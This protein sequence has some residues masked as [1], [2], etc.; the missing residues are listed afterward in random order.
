MIDIV[1]LV[2]ISYIYLLYIYVLNAP[3]F[4]CRY[5]FSSCTFRFLILSVVCRAVSDPVVMERTVLEVELKGTCE[6]YNVVVEPTV[7]LVPGQILQDTVVRR[8]FKVIHSC[9]N[10]VLCRNLLLNY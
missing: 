6:S 10:H 8:K 5:F 4:N 7:I 1:Q 3:N 2:V 9:M